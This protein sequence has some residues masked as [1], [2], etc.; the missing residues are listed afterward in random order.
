MTTGDA[1]GNN[2]VTGRPLEGHIKIKNN[3]VTHRL[4][5]A[6]F[7]STFN[8]SMDPILTPYQMALSGADEQGFV[9]ETT[10]GGHAM[11]SE[12]QMD[13][14]GNFT[15][16]SGA[17]YTGSE[18]L[19]DVLHGF[20]PY[21]V[22]PNNP[23]SIYNL[24]DGAYASIAEKLASGQYVST[25]IRPAPSKYGHY[26]GCLIGLTDFPVEFLK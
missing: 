22:N 24:D 9:F 23:Y 21:D 10:A 1:F 19:A 4:D 6:A 17:S 7:N 15:G 3:G 11:I 20:A 12:A 25:Y 5:M 13:D 18:T 8:G 14:Q 26:L 2:T 16:F